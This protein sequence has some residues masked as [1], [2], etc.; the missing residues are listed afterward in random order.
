VPSV[1]V[2]GGAG[3][4]GRHIVDSLADAG[5]HVVSYNRDF[6]AAP[7]DDVSVAQGE[8]FDIPRL[9]S[10]LREHS[11]QII[12]HTAALSHPTYSLDFPV[13]T[14]AANMEGTVAVFEAARMHGVQRVINCSS[15]TVY[16]ANP[17]PLVVEADP[18]NPTT[19]YAVT[20]VA[21]EW[22][23]KVYRD[24]YGLDV[25]SLRISQVYGPGNRM[26]EI[27]RDV[28]RGVVHD[29]G[30]AIPYGR[31]HCYN[32]IYVR[33]MAAAA[34]AAVQSAGVVE[35][36]VAYNISSD[37]Y[38][39]LGDVLDVVAELH[40]GAL[41]AAGPGLDPTLDLQGQFSISS[42]TRD[43][44]FTPSW[45]LRRALPDYAEWLAEHDY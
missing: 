27:L 10:V 18:V 20:K 32:F 29:D 36:P 19:P 33:D 30:F 8:L 26:D 7:R 37:E 42:A 15:R 3:F 6:S 12:V 38:W 39:R 41:L 1:L 13:A 45:H 4:S 34:V 11:V 43:L 28:M 23:G 16:G 14:F 25:I 22:L 35:R 17:N 21:G 5:M 24:R 44:G 40:P 9:L 31:D 2:T